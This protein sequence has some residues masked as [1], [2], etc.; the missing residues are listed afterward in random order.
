MERPF[1]S[2][3]GLDLDAIG[4][5]QEPDPI[6]LQHLSLLRLISAHNDMDKIV[7]CS[8]YGRKELP[9]VDQLLSF[10][11]ELLQWRANAQET[12][13]AYEDLSVPFT[14][15]AFVDLPIPPEPVFLRRP[16]TA[17]SIA[18]FNCY[19]ACTLSM[20]ALSET[21]NEYRDARELEAFALT[22]QNLQLAAGFLA[23]DNLSHIKGAAPPNRIVNRSTQLDPSITIALFLGARRCF[24]AQWYDWTIFALRHLGRSGLCDGRALANC[25]QILDDSVHHPISDNTLSSLGRLDERT[26]PILMPLSSE[27]GV[28]EAFY[29]RQ[30]KGLFIVVAKATWQQREQGLPQ[31][32]VIEQFHH[33]GKADQGLHLTEL[34]AD[35]QDPLK[36]WKQSL[37]EGWHTF[38]NQPQRK[39]S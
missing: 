19:M 21:D 22:Y 35:S 29:L 17:I 20:L 5:S 2:N 36:E 9:A 7:W 16:S 32:L 33:E 4:S 13:S 1:Y 15:G 37:E 23:Q 14:P 11:A 31:S 24:K 12:F 26:V 25:L 27:N 39:W 34:T 28:R 38:V 18:Y 30:S 3:S 6:S 8:F 10:H